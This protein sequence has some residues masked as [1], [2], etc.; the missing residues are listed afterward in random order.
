MLSFSPTCRNRTVFVAELIFILWLVVS[1]WLWSMLMLIQCPAWHG[2]V[3][4]LE[5]CE[6]VWLESYMCFHNL[7][8]TPRVHVFIKPTE[9]PERCHKPKLKTIMYGLLDL[10]YLIVYLSLQSFPDTV[11]CTQVDGH[12]FYCAKQLFLCIKLV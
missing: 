12:N 7:V 11:I 4:Y 10:I 2:P 3:G 1:C 5:Y 6:I 8:S 9:S